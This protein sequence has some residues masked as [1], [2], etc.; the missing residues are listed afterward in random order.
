VYTP[1]YVY[2]AGDLREDGQRC[3]LDLRSLTI[4]WETECD[5]F[6]GNRQIF[7]WSRRHLRRGAC[8]G[9]EGTGLD[10]SEIVSITMSGGTNPDGSKRSAKRRSPYVCVRHSLVCTEITYGSFL[11][12][13]SD[14]HAKKKTF[15]NFLAAFMAT[16]KFVP[17]TAVE[18]ARI[19]KEQRP[20]IKNLPMTLHSDAKWPENVESKEIDVHGIR[21]L[22]ESM[23][24]VKLQGNIQKACQ[25]LVPGVTNA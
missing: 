1:P 10:E 19:L 8:A 23:E 24:S 13:A 25:L 4:F 12:I 2:A 6:P 9:R 15:V 17:R 14:A 16:S 3:V 21:S 5:N 7:D 22:C 18:D 20:I 11:S